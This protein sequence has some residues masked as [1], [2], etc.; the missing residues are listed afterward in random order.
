M[1]HFMTP[2]DY[3]RNSLELWTRSAEIQLEMT[4]FAFGMAENMGQ[5][6]L[7]GPHIWYAA[8]TAANDVVVRAPASVTTLKDERAK[9]AAKP[10][11]KPVAKTAPKP[12]AKPAAKTAKAQPKAAAKPAPAKPATRAPAAKLGNSAPKSA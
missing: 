10:A 9:R 7:S 4:R 8:G 3:W 5:T 6:I 2:M 1:Y 11:A 12:A